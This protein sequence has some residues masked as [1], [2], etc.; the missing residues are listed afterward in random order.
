MFSSVIRKI[1]FSGILKHNVRMCFNTPTI[2]TE[3]VYG[4]NCPKT[5][6]TNDAETN[7]AETKIVKDAFLDRFY[8]KYDG[9][10]QETLTKAAYMDRFNLP[11]FMIGG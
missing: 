9:S 7:D 1:H 2:I 11:T 8:T 3:H 5:T 10:Y 4:A 6:G